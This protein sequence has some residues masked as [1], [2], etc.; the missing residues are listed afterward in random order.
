MYNTKKDKGAFLA[1]LFDSPL[2][3]YVQKESVELYK[4][5][6]AKEKASTFAK[7][8]IVGGNA[9]PTPQSMAVE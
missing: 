9:C 3:T 5:A 4:G 1:R 2:R 7:A 6:K 8:D